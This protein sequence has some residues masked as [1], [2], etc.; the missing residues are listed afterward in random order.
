MGSAA[1]AV[2]GEELLQGQD[3]AKDCCGE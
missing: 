2:T 3:G 1:V